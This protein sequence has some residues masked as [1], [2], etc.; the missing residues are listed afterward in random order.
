MLRHTG[1]SIPRKTS[2]SGSATP[3]SERSLSPIKS[4]RSP[5]ISPSKQGSPRRQLSPYTLYMREHFVALKQKLKDDKKAIFQMCHQMWEEEADE[6]KALYERRS[7]EEAE[8]DE[9]LSGHRDMDDSFGTGS[10]QSSNDRSSIFSDE[11]TDD[12]KIRNFF[13]T[14]RALNLESAVQF[15]SLVAAHHI[16]VDTRDKVHLDIIRLLDRAMIFPHSLEEI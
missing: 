15:A 12:E 13:M 1:M 16:D 7:I 5:I 6:V 10:Q 2:E 11:N 14:N 3:Q 4:P 8:N 9:S